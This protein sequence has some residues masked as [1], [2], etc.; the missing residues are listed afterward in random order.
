M[1]STIETLKQKALL[2]ESEG[3]QIVKLEELKIPPAIIMKSNDS[4]LYIT[5]DLAAAEYRHKTFKFEKMLYVVGTP[6]ALHFQQLFAVLD[7]MGHAWA[8]NCEHVGFGHLSFKDDSTGSTE[9]MSTRSGNIIFLKDVLH[10]AMEMADQIIREKRPELEERQKVIEQVAIA[11]L[12]YADFSAKRRKDVKFSWQDILNFD[13]ETGPYLQYTSV[14]IRSVLE[15]F[16]GKIIPEV[17]FNKLTHPEEKEL[18]KHLANFSTTVVVAAEEK[19]P[20]I[21]AH[22]LM[23]LAKLFNK[24]YS[25]YR[26]LDEDGETSLA[27]VLLTYCTSTVL[28]AGLKLLGI[29]LPKKM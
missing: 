22:Y 6:Q 1:P 27:R 13:G 24:F 8:K 17:D 9:A 20:F 23:D 28:D 10:K 4:T 2:E 25:H 29:P 3:A 18:I 5:R 19:E 21:V 11:A 15:K 26:V 7:K 12:I 16:T 14:R